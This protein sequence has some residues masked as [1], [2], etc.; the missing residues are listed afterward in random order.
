[1]KKPSGKPRGFFYIPFQKKCLRF[2]AKAAKA[3][4]TLMK[5][6][7]GEE[8]TKSGDLSGRQQQ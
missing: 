2:T 1:M 4:T 3:R 6:I 7:M 5:C 8:T